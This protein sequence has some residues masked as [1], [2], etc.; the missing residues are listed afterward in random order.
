[1]KI[2]QKKEKKPGHRVLSLVSGLAFCRWLGG[3]V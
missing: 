1:M 3:A 2:E